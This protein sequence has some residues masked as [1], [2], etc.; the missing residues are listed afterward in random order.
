MYIIYP[1][2][3]PSIFKFRELSE[4][5]FH[6]IHMIAPTPKNFNQRLRREQFFFSLEHFKY[7]V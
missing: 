4:R 6:G 7:T 1:S 3:K 2:S 5:F